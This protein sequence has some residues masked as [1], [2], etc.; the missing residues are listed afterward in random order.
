MIEC[1]SYRLRHPISQGR[2]DRLVVI[3]E[4]FLEVVLVYVRDALKPKDLRVV[5]PLRVHLACLSFDLPKLALVVLSLD[6]LITT[7]S[8]NIGPSTLVLL[9]YRR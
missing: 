4:L 1:L 6:V 7:T 5:R 9:L 2:L 8:A 3:V